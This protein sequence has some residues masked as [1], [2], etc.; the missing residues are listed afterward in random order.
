MFVQGGMTNME[1]LRCATLYG[2]EYIGLD[3]DI[4]SLEEGKLADLIVLDENPLDDI[5]NSEL[6]QYT[7]INGRI[8]DAMTMNEVGNHPR[9]RTAFYWERPGSSDAFVWRGE[10]VGFE[11]NHCSCF[12]SQ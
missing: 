9:E 11:L 6:V 10:G 5:R 8:Y 3:R 7:M 1:A 4:G 12:R 2:A